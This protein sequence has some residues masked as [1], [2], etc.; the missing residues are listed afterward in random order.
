MKLDYK[1]WNRLIWW[2]LTEA[3]F[4]I[5]IMAI[6]PP[7]LF[8]SLFIEGTESDTYTDILTIFSLLLFPFLVTL[9][10]ARMETT[11]IKM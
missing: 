5:F 2:Q 7:I 4:F 10:A 3:R 1:V 6:A 9:W 8:F 11:A